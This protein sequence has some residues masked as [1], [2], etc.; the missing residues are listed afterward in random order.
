MTVSGTTCAALSTLTELWTLMQ[1][2]A[3]GSSQII[4]LTKECTRLVYPN[5]AMTTSKIGSLVKKKTITL[6]AHRLKNAFSNVQRTEILTLARKA[7]TISI[8]TD[9]RQLTSTTAFTTE[10]TCFCR[11]EL[12]GP[13]SKFPW[14]MPLPFQFLLL[15]HL[16]PF[17]SLSDRLE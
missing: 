11:V 14:Q 16:L 3:I 8:L 17:Y 13:T 5:W 12:T 4:M 9:W 6:S 15:Q 1:T 7:R 2:A 10:K